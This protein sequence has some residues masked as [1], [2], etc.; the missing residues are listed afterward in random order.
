VGEH[1]RNRTVGRTSPLDQRAGDASVDRPVH[2]EIRHR[3]LRVK[4]SLKVCYRS[5]VGANSGRRGGW[6]ARC[7]SERVVGRSI[8]MVWKGSVAL[9]PQDLS[10]S[11]KGDLSV[12]SRKD[13][14]ID[15]AIFPM[16]RHFGLP[17]VALQADSIYRSRG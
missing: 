16:C 9:R 13:L 2:I 10:P 15:I 17:I 5:C 11:S 1:G 6:Y 7:S 8:V 14:G 4:C 3:A 12:V